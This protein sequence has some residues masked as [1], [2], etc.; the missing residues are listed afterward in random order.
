MLSLLVSLFAQPVQAAFTSW[1][2]RSGDLLYADNNFNG[3]YDTGELYHK[4]GYNFSNAVVTRDKGNWSYLTAQEMDDVTGSLEQMGVNLIRVYTLPM[5]SVTGSLTYVTGIR[6]YNEISMR[7]LDKFIQLAGVHNIRVIVPII[8]VHSFVGGIKEFAGFRGLAASQFF[9]DATLKQDFKN[10]AYDLVNRINYYTGVAYKN[11]PMILAWQLGNELDGGAGWSAGWEAG[12][13]AYLK[14]I[15]PNHLVMSGASIT[16]STPNAALLNDPNVDII[17]VHPYSYFSRPLVYFTDNY[18]SGTKGKKPFIVDEMDD[19]VAANVGTVYSRMTVAANRNMAGALL[20]AF[21]G[22]TDI[23]GFYRRANGTNWWT[24]N[25]PGGSVGEASNG[26]IT[27]DNLTRQYAYQIEGLPVPALPAPG[28]PVMLASSMKSSIRFKGGI[29]GNT[30]EI[31]RALSSIGPW[32]TL[33]TTYRDYGNG[34]NFDVQV[35]Y[36][37]YNDTSAPV[38]TVYYRA[39]AM[40]TGGVAGAWSN[41]IAV[42]DANV[43]VMDN[44]DSSGV[45][46]IGDWSPS[47]AIAGYVGDDYVHDGNTGGAEDKKM[48]YTPPIPQNGTYKVYVNYTSHANRATN[49]RVDVTSASG[50]STY[51][52]N[53]QSGGGAYVQLGTTFTFNA[54]STHNVTILNNGASGYVVAD[55]VKFVRQ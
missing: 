25:W 9:T 43:I 38:G 47:T 42:T 34:Y 28:A 29:G 52:V 40:N 35:A 11:D 18:L 49:V 27:K 13:A 8:D 16:S 53:Q 2:K 37:P 10:L 15:D 46:V 22:H 14:S 45:T 19:A 55:S 50:T 24:Y 12:M 44:S 17:S 31:Q 1:V 6:T 51:Y 39:R 36:V 5:G 41:A 23:G 33:T 20:W 7:Q 3:V 4:T 30:Y 48:I 32:T 21:K 26:E 54:G